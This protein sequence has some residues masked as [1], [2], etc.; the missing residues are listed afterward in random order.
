MCYV[1]LFV[2]LKIPDNIALTAHHTLKTR[3]GC[4]SLQALQRSEFWEIQFLGLS[5]E[6]AEQILEKWVQK[7]ALFANP[8]KHRYKILPSE[9]SITD[10]ESFLLEKDA[11]VLVCD[12]EDSKAEGTMEALRGMEEDVNPASLRRGI[13][14]DLQFDEIPQKEIREI[15]EDIAVTRSRGRGLLSNPHYQIHYSFFAQ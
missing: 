13:W 6:Q 10:M 7:T 14:W 8:N 12:I 3:L 1:F 4:T 2:S 15:V 5:P 9:Q 11:S